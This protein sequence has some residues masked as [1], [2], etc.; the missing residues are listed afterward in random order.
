EMLFT[1]LH[2]AREP[3]ALSQNLF[4]MWYLLENY[5]SNPEIKTLVDNTELYFIPIVNPDGYIYNQQTNPNGGGYWRKNRRNNG[6]S[7]G[8]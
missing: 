8:I 7:Y 6:G 2:H 1:S 5:N 3:I 4:Y